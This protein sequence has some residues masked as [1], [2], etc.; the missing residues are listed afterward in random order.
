MITKRALDGKPYAGNPHVRFD[1]G[2]VASAALPRRV[3]LFYRKI[4][5]GVASATLAAVFACQG[6]LS[7]KFGS[8]MEVEID[9]EVQT[10]ANNAVWTTPTNV[11]CIYRMRPVL[12]SGERTFDVETTGSAPNYFFPQY[13]EGNWVRVALAGNDQITLT[14]K[15][16]STVYYADAEH[17][18]DDWDGTTDYEH[19]DEST[20]P[21]KGPKKTL[22]AAHDVAA[23]GNSTIGFPLVSVAPGVYDEGVTTTYSSGTSN[24]CKRRLYV[25]KSIGFIATDGAERTIIVG[26]PDSSTADGKGGDAIG[27]VQIGISEYGRAFLQGFTITRCYSPATQS[28]VNQY[29]TAVCGG[30]ARAYILDCIISNNVATTYPVGYLGVVMRS[31]IY[32][33]TAYRYLFQYGT[34]VSCVFSANSITIGNS[35]G[36]GYALTQDG[37]LRFCTVDL[38]TD[39]NTSSGRYQLQNGTKLYGTL[40]YG[41][42]DQNTI[43]ANWYDS[44]ATNMPIF[45]DVSARDYRLGMKSPAMDAV[46]YSTLDDT[47]RRW[48]TADVDGRMPVLHDG[49]MPCGALLRNEPEDRYVDCVNGDDVNDGTS[50]AQAKRTIRAAM[51]ESVSGDTIYVAPGVYGE[52][53]GSQ[54]WPSATSTVGAR[55]VVRSG[56]TVES[57]GGAERTFIVGAASPE[58]SVTEGW[59]DGIGTGAVRCVAAEDDS[60][61]RGFTL[62]GGYTHSDESTVNANKYGSAFFSRNTRMA[63]IEDCIISNNVACL[64]TIYQAVVRR[65]RVVGNAA[66]TADVNT[67]SG[68]AGCM[69]AWHNSIIAYNRGNH[70]L[71]QPK[72]VENC[73]LG[74]GNVWTSSGNSSQVLSYW[75]ANPHSLVNTAWLYGRL[76]MLSGGILYCTNCIVLNS[77]KDFDWSFSH[78]TI[79]T[80]AAAMQVDSEFRPI[81]GSFAGIDRGDISVSTEALGDT[82]IYGTARILNGALDIGA[83]EYDWRPAFAA[84]LG[85]RFTMTYASP[86]VT[87]NETGGLLVEDGVVAGTAN[88]AGSYAIVFSLTGGSLAVY[89]DGELAGESS[90]TGE[91]SIPFRVANAADEIKFVY[92]PGAQSTA[93]LKRFSGAGGF[94]ISFR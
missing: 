44:I 61:L 80:N 14:G 75:D 58:P 2:E 50:V 35:T 23:A 13:G 11:P 89:V 31:K 34:Y 69:C 64:Y 56:V 66:A 53:E 54:P 76:Q 20:T 26:E 46:E 91:Q 6:E 21:K 42:R 29:G 93:V 70:T 49:K 82:D 83:V 16:V 43:D 45:A 57:T 19:R 79:F 8:A 47:T 71:L 63:T 41:L 22:Q 94:S 62:T 78:K 74:E 12:A 81:F 37:A 27:G 77:M 84:E 28:A 38:T 85:R 18:N 59:Q 68:A 1:E 90:G 32:A 40:V 86:S 36:P 4:N 87:K 33:N 24:P 72:V 60:T 25:T 92:T 7:V 55:V 17:G 73:T 9:G 30:S 51:D 39:G 10:F 15:K 3:S 67:E 52:Q 48:L 5:L 65:C 88:S